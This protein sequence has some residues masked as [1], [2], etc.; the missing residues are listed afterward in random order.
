[1]YQTLGEHQRAIEDFSNALQLLE[2]GTGG[3]DYYHRGVLCSPSAGRR[4][5]RTTW[6]T[7]LGWRD[8]ALFHTCARARR[9]WATTTAR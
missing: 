5:H 6:T 8:A 2:P 7:E 4:T 9:R 3:E 1:M